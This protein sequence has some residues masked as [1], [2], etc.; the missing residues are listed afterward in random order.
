M[1]K[2]KALI[3]FTVLASTAGC[4]CGTT[5][6]G[7][8]SPDYNANPKALSFEACPNKDE[9]GA[10]VKDVY[11]DEQKFTLSNQGK[12]SG[13]VVISFSGPDATAF[14]LVEGK[15]PTGLGPNPDSVEIPVR[16]SPSKKGDSVATM[17]IEDGNDGTTPVSVSLVGTGRNLLSQPTLAVALQNKDLRTQFD[18]CFAGGTCLMV[19][20]DTFYK[21]SSTLQINVE[22]KGCPA[23]KITGL[24][25]AASAPTAPLPFTVDQPAV[26]PTMQTPL[27]LTTA[28]GAAKTTL[29]LRFSPEEIAGGDTQRYGVLKVFTND[30][31]NAEFDITLFGTAS[32]PALYVQPTYCD[33]SDSADTCGY[34]NRVANQGQFELKNGGNTPI[35][36]DSVKLNN[37]GQNGRFSITQN[38]QGQT[39]ATGGSAFV[40]V[41]HTDAPLYVGDLLTISASAGGNPAGTAVI[42]LF[43]GKK[44]CL[45]TDP[46]D[47]LDFQDP[48]AELTPKTVAVKNGPGCGDL[49]LNRVFVDPNPF[50]SVVAPLLPAG[51]KIPAGGS[52]NIT[53][54]YKKPVSGGTQTGVLRI[55]SNDPD[56]GPTPYKVVRL[57]SN[58]PLDQV[59]VA[60]IKG[61]L[62]TDPN[63][64]AAQG[65]SMSVH[66]SALSPRE[67][68]MTGK[69]STDPGNTSAT[70]I[71]G[72]RF[73]LIKPNNATGASLEND[74]LK[75]P[76][77]TAKLTLDPTATGTYRVTLTVWDSANQ[78]SFSAAELTISV[79]P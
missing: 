62:P 55:D 15:I 59:P 56:F 19:F 73:K 61:C 1:S 38:A 70:P 79:N 31:A 58:S 27:I 14:S 18:D 46:L 26:L 47:Q 28:D 67:L 72:Y 24:E 16:F 22:N 60:D 36:I 33:F 45:I 20:P 71:S 4:R 51:D 7:T 52:H 50:F 54:Q 34:A 10:P 12:A 41:S 43:G 77:S 53:V 2:L 40:K 37:G 75:S 3:A 30:P 65:P 5:G 25:L 66:L 76:K 23:L 57:Y 29:S 21:E 35:V 49:I 48:T 68:I 44:P 74:G 9:A 78:Q 8:L 42:S 17:T 13:T 39:I 63:C 6:T 64:A 32:A 11:P 69:D